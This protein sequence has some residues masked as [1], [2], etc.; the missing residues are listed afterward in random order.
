MPAFKFQL[1]G[2]SP[3]FADASVKLVN[4]ATGATLERKPF[5]DG[6]LVMSDL[7]A[8]Q[9]EVEL[10]HPNVL[11]PIYKQKIKLFPQVPPTFVPLPVDPNLF[12]DSP[13]RDIPDADL[14]PIAQAAQAA[15]DKLARIG[16]KQAG[17]AIRAADWNAMVSAMGELAGAV[18]EITRRLSAVGHEHPEIEEKID[19][20]QDNLR[21]FAD[22]FGKSLLGIQREL[23][24]DNLRASA[25]EAFAGVP[26]VIKDKVK[27]RLD[28]L[29]PV[30]DADPRVVSKKLSV[31]GATILTAINEAATAA[32]QGGEDFL[33]KPAVAALSQAAANYV[34]M[35]IV[36]APDKESKLYNL[37]KKAFRQR[38]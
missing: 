22:A 11:I 17:E 35:G 1:Q 4:T 8:G 10:K 34:D 6:S 5:L 20:V 12:K 38:K 27:K 28:E 31:T 2:F 26:E 13:V 23:E 29:V 19:E 32:G 3:A 16:N 36:D 25:D 18:T 14:T 7:D 33:K 15:K 37:N 24:H 21:R 9:Y 30:I